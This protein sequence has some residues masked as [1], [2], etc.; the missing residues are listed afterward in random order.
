MG[1]L[2]ALLALLAVAM[3][4][5]AGCV[6][7]ALCE[8]GYVTE[9]G[10]CE[11]QCVASRCK[12]G[13][14]CVGNRCV[15]PC[16]D[17]G[18][19]LDGQACLEASDDRGGAIRLCQQT[20]RRPPFVDPATNTQP[21]GYGWA[22]PFGDTDCRC[23]FGVDNCAVQPAACPNGLEC[24]P[25]TCADCAQDAAVCQGDPD[26]NVGRCGDGTPCTFNTCEL[27]QCRPF[28]CVG[29]GEGDANAYCTQHDCDSDAA[30]PLGYYC[31]NTRA[32][33]DICGNTCDGGTCSNDA[34]VACSNDGQC[35]KG[36]NANCGTT[37][38]PC[39]DIAAANAAGARYF[40]SGL[41]L[42]R[43]TC[44]VRDECTRC[45]DNLDCSLGDAQVCGAH[46]GQDVCLRLCNDGTDC[47]LDENCVSYA[48]ASGGAGNTCASN[49]N[50]DCE[51][52]DDCPVPGD[53]CVPRSVC[54]PAAGACDASDSSSKFCR[55][56]VDDED[57]GGA[58]K[59]GR[60]ACV[61][62]TNGERACF[63]LAFSFT[64]RSDEDCPLS[65]RGRHGACLDDEVG[66]N[67]SVYQ[68]C[69]FPFCDAFDPLGA[70]NPARYTCN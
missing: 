66:P 18:D 2:A 60:W 27:S 36:N 58:D 12:A 41:C 55:H 21:G 4:P 57:C 7:G 32:P 38:E 25:N 26:C 62:V 31:G 53:L 5:A 13:N 56:C 48:P 14:V 39:I 52:S 43:P 24:D 8:G 22:C 34:A 29:A 65:P 63:D 11:A 28:S 68:R 49:A 10:T 44:L 30:C 64:C 46:A 23:P 15:L 59:P 9:D 33:H 70:C 69:Y 19:C 45:R 6:T 17:H 67:S 50:V 20:R 47:R 54:V 61:E 1:F 3:A 42:M 51:T 40:E 37:D 16:V 35:Q